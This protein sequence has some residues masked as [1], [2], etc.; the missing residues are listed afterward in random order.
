MKYISYSPKGAS[1]WLLCGC[2]DGRGRITLLEGNAFHPHPTTL[3]FPF[4]RCVAI[5]MT[6]SING[7]FR[8]PFPSDRGNP[9]REVVEKGKI[10][11]NNNTRNFMLLPWGGGLQVP[12][13][14]SGPRNRKGRHKFESL[15][16]NRWYKR[17]LK[18]NVKNFD[19]NY[20]YQLN[21]CCQ[22]INLISFKLLHNN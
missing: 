12:R 19:G 9:C 15:A 10:K 7:E 5:Q 4:P 17:E 14:D 8:A 2:D 1:S 3:P 11:C 13:E 22:F 20:S 16:S 21:W 18:T 6:K